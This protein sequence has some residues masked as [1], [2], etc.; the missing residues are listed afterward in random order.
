[1]LV[2]AANITMWSAPWDIFGG[3]YSGKSL[4]VAAQD[5][6]P[7]GLAF[8]SDG[9][10]VYVLGFEKVRVSQYTLSTAWDIS[11]GSYASKSLSVSTQDETSQDLAFSPDGTKVYVL[12]DSNNRIYQY[13]LI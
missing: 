9:T 10:K 11:T 12:G 13:E 8:S 2:A 4:S 5:A 6:S 1:M 7:A 3:Y